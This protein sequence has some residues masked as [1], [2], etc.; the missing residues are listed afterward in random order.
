MSAMMPVPLPMNAG[1][2][3]V[4]PGVEGT[5]HCMTQPARPGTP[6][7]VQKWRKSNYATP[8]QRIVHPGM[9][10]D[11]EGRDPTAQEFG[12]ILVKSD[13]V[14][15]VWRQPGADSEYNAVVHAQKEAHYASV[16]HEPLGK[17]YN[18]G[19]ALPD[20]TTER[21]FQFGKSSSSSE[22]AKSLLYPVLTEDQ[23]QFQPQYIKSHGSF[24]PGEQRSRDYSWKVDPS[25]HRFGV[26]VG[27]Q[28]ALNGMALGV[29]AALRG[30]GDTHPAVVTSKKVEDSKSLADQLGRARNLGHGAVSQAPGGRHIYGK[31]SIRGQSEWDARQCI[32]GE[33]HYDEQ[34]PDSDLGCSHTPGFRNVTNEVRA[35]GTPT[36]RSDIPKYTRR[37][38][39]DNQNYGDDVNA[40]FLL[41]PSLFSHIGVENEH[42]VAP[43]DRGEIRDLFAAIGETFE[44]LEY[45]ELCNTA[46]AKFG[47]LTIDTFRQVMNLKRDFEEQF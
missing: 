12:A 3:G 11:F 23:E 25:N 43:R 7:E 31:A 21:K 15:D 37:S 9:I 44:E 27:S 40:Q 8:G 45:E 34:M 16:K 6:P 39:A 20:K 18:R 29:S 32:Q 5:H 1:K 10:K 4:E 14:E 42:F 2:P 28:I 35:F 24:A 46:E 41:Y 30:E 38:I 47:A 33:F 26:G 13:H 17:S 19:H 22:D 36:V